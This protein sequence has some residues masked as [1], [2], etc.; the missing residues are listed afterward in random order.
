MISALF[1]LC[2]FST[3]LM[4]P[5]WWEGLGGLGLGLAMGFILII[6]NFIVNPGLCTLQLLAQRS[7]KILPKF[8]GSLVPPVKV[9]ALYAALAAT[10]VLLVWFMPFMLLPAVIVSTVC[11]LILMLWPRGVFAFR[12]SISLAGLYAPLTGGMALT[13]LLIVTILWSVLKGQ[14]NSSYS[15]G[16]N[17]QE[18]ESVRQS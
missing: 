12:A 14:N 2:L 10:C 13:A 9:L 6:L 3:K 11:S 18:S 5:S 1:P 17:Q 4:Q 7:L 8:A 16:S 15:V